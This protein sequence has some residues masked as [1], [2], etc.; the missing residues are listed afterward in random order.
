MRSLKP[1]VALVVVAALAVGLGLPRASAAG[2]HL[3]RQTWGDV[4]TVTDMTAE[5]RALTRPTPEQPVYYRGHSLGCKLG[6]IPGER[7]PEVE[8][9][10][11][12]VAKILAKQ[13]YLGARPGVHEPTLFLVL[14]WG[15]LEPASGDLLWFLGYDANQDIAA[16]SFPGM[17]GPE[18]WR[19]DFRSP[20]IE[21]ILDYAG[22]PIYGIIVTAFEFQ[23]AST[24]RPIIYWQTRIALPANGKSMAQALPTMALAGGP[25]IGRETKSPVLNSADNVNKGHVELGELKVIGYEDEPA[26]PSKASGAKK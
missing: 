10:C 11:E 6:S 4:I 17:L 21:R 1:D 15:Y 8:E 26:P 25:T 24:P 12:F 22:G 19:R 20:T 14:Q 2:F 7:L 5:G 9:L 13:G 16:P 18:V 23:S 3:F